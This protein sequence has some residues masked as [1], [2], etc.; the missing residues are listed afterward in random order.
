MKYILT[1]V[2]IAIFAGISGYFLG[3]NKSNLEETLTRIT[4]V[5]KNEKFTSETILQVNPYG[6]VRAA[7]MSHQFFQTE[8]A[9]IKSQENLSRAIDDYDLEKLLGKNKEELIKEIAGSVEIA[10]ERGTDLIRLEVSADSELK[11][12]Q[13]AY[14]VTQTYS[15]RRTEALNKRRLETMNV[16][17]DKR[18]IQEDKVEDHRTRL[19]ALSKRLQIPHHGGDARLYANRGLDV[20]KHDE[21]ARLDARKGEGGLIVSA[22]EKTKFGKVR[23]DY[24]REHVI[25]DAI[26]EAEFTEKIGENLERDPL[27][28]HQLGW[29]PDVTAA[30]K[31]AE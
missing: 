4:A 20:N 31:R 21:K 12:Q 3:V 26:K 10:Q 30:M 25:L 7:M 13:I 24:E 9:V 8:F 27:V 18:R 29:T 11:A 14:A 6:T 1:T 16:F 22:E 2:V 19:Y 5:E 15:T 17:K 23:E 28:F